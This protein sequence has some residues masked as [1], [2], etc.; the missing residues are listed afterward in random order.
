MLA[1][2]RGSELDCT[3]TLSVPLI[4]ADLL[5]E[6]GING[7]VTHEPGHPCAHHVEEFTE[8]TFNAVLRAIKVREFPHGPITYGII[9]LP[10]GIQGEVVGVSERSER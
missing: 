6:V 8:A 2:P 7:A 1:T 10:Q 5:L 3:S 9:Y 4:S